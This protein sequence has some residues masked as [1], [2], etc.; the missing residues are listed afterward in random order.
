M[1]KR[2]GSLLLAVFLLLAAVPFYAVPVW[3]EDSLT[4]PLGLVYSI[5]VETGK[6]VGAVAGVGFQLNGTNYVLSAPAHASGQVIAFVGS[7]SEDAYLLE[8][9]GS[10][11]GGILQFNEVTDDIGS[12]TKTFPRCGAVHKGESVYV[13]CING[14]DD[15]GTIQFGAA[16]STAESMS[17]NWL[18]LSDSLRIPNVPA[19]VVNAKGQLCAVGDGKQ[20]FA[21]GVTDDTFYESGSKPTEGPAGTAPEEPAP[22][23]SAPPTVPTEAPAE[24]TPSSKEVDLNKEIALPT[25]HVEHQV[26]KLKKAGSTMLIVEICLGIVLAAAV[27][28]A[29]VLYLKKKKNAQR[30][31]HTEVE[32]GTQLNGWQDSGLTLQCV[33]GTLA[34]RQFPIQEHMTIGRDTDN[35]LVIP[36]Q[37]NTVSGH[38]CE[39]VVRNGVTYLRDVGS[40]NGTFIGTH[41]LRP[42]APVELKPGMQLTVGGLQA[43]EK[44]LIR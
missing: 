9:Q 42:G 16:E 2:L 3:A 32:E 14:I 7:E 30:V 31:I 43:G 28:A 24:T 23:E 10:L 29:V 40:R 12:D 38:H 6:V 1:M 27:A 5:D 37:S 39:I 25:I 8:A 17:D 15:N 33:S 21:L 19:M 35:T 44:F 4:A 13:I 36:P 18:T 11:G 26:V 20:Y 41:R 34:G 22:P